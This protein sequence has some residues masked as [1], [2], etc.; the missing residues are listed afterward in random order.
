MP[1]AC[2]RCGDLVEAQKD[3]FQRVYQDDGTFKYP[4]I[5]E[6]QLRVEGNL[7]FKNY[8]FT[9]ISLGTKKDLK[10][11]LLKLYK[12]EI[13]PAL[14]EKVVK[15]LSDNG[16]VRVV[17]MKQEDNAGLHND[18]TYLYEIGEEFRKRDTAPFACIECT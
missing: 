7:Y 11:S 3:L 2:I 10:C 6:N 16:K 18:K 14:E 13:I 12:E 1:I 15:Q 5:N 4:H 8:N 9:G 17:I